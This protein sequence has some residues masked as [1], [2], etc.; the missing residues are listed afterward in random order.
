MKGAM[1]LAAVIPLLG[2]FSG[3]LMLLTGLIHIPGCAPVDRVA[4]GF[5]S[6]H[7]RMW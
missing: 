2:V 4:S 5:D 6:L 3:I 1:Q 7:E